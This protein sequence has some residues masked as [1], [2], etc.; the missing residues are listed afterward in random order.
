MPSSRPGPATTCQRSRREPGLVHQLDA[1]QGGEHGLR[2]GLGDH[3]VA[4]HQRG[5]AV[6]QRHRERVVP[7]RDDADD[8]L[9]DAVDV[10]PGE[11]RDHAAAP[12]GRHVLAGHP[13]VVAGRQ[14]G[15]GDLVVGVLAG[16]AVLQ[17]DDVEQLRHP[18]EQQVVEPQHDRSTLVH[19]RPRPGRLGDPRP[20]DRPR[21]RR[22]RWTAGCWPAA[23]RSAATSAARWCRSWRATRSVRLATYSGSRTYD[24]RGSCSGSCGP[25]DERP[26]SPALGKAVGVSGVRSVSWTERSEWR[27]SR[28]LIGSRCDPLHMLFTCQRPILAPLTAW[29]SSRRRRSRRSPR[30]RRRSPRRRGPRGAR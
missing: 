27:H 28:L 2:V 23:P 6:G 4:G 24:A 7:R 12:L 3:R 29:R 16:L 9:G 25:V 14:C 11:E 1:E 19:R 10:D 30:A 20:R 5:K 26:A 18:L 13:R 17:R 21:R 22:R 15:V 8:A